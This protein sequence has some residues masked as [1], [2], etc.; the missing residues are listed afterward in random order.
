MPQNCVLTD[1]FVYFET[2]NFPGS[3]ATFILAPRL[4]KV[5][6]LQRYPGQSGKYRPITDLQDTKIGVDVFKQAYLQLANNYNEVF[7]ALTSSQINRQLHSSALQAAEAVKGRISLQVIDS[8]T[9]GPGLGAVVQ[10]AAYEI[11]RDATLSEVYRQTQKYINHVYSFFCLRELKYLSLW[12]TF[13]SEH[14]IIGDFLGVAPVMILE[15]GKIVNTQK[16]RNSRHLIELVIE[17]LDEFFTIKKVYLFQSTPVFG[18]E[19]HQLRDRI[20]QTF[21]ELPLVVLPENE[22]SSY[23]FGK[24]SLS[25]IV[26][27]A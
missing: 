26:M 18:N 17:Y 12:G 7:V 3:E 25:M 2:V 19:F 20:L 13:N 4:G 21:P 9:F 15:N 10:K 6:Q 1:P 5:I 27:D 14:A 16:A 23:L 22:F 11:S 8:Q 24:R